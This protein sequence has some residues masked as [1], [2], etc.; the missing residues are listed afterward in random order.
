MS[1]RARVAVL[2]TKPETVLEDYR[3]LLRLAGADRCLKPGTTTILKDNISWHYPMP[4]A[5]T[6][7]WQL[8]GTILGLRDL[9]YTDISCVQN[10][11][12]VID[13]HKGEDLN[14]YVP[15]F[16]HYGIPVLYNFKDEDMKWVPFRPR[17][18]MLALDHI[19][20]EGIRIPDYFF[21][22]NIVHLPT[23]KCHI[24]TTT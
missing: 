11:T 4:S 19:Y 9:G 8:E 20:P 24:Y 3:R 10:K 16:R 17:A 13:T 2:R 21:G 5:N 14:L 7:P 22:R 12:V 15:I 23:A 6:T 18:G 1:C